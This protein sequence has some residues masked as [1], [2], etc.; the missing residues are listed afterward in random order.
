MKR[1]L[2]SMI[3]LTGF[4]TTAQ[5][6]TKKKVYLTAGGN[7]GILSFA[8]VRDDGERV[9]TVPRFTLFFNFGT[10]YN[11]DVTDHFGF[12]S[13]TNIKNIGLITKEDGMKVKSRVY[14]LGVPL[15]FKAGDIKGG[16]VFFAGGE[17][18]FALNYKEKLFI[19]VDKKS[20]FNEWFSDRTPIVMPSVFVGVDLKSHFSFKAQ[21]YLNNF[22]NTGFEENGVK[23]YENVDAKVFFI[24]LGYKFRPK[25]I[26]FHID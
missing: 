24:T 8:D 1:L 12:F 6:Q 14:T 13:G 21:Y 17:L 18:D 23:P 5:A 20:K 2:L 3:V 10:N 19:D 11:L 4:F 22:F 9:N 26:R 15:G 25:K 16:N 7:A